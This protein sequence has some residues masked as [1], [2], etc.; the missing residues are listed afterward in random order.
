MMLA[1][2]TEFMTLRMEDD[3]TLK[4]TNGRYVQVNPDLERAC[5]NQHCCCSENAET[6]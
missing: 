2:V 1:A 4:D 6:L 5:A 3:D